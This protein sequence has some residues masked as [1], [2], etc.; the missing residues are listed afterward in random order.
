MGLRSSGDLTALRTARD[1]GRRDASREERAPRRSPARCRPRSRRSDV[2]RQVA[3]GQADRRRRDGGRL[4]GHASQRA[5]GGPQATA[6]PVR[7]RS[8]DPQALSTRGVRRQQD[9]SP[10]RRRDPRRRHR[11]GRRTVSGHGAARRRVAVG[12]ALARRAACFP[13]PTRWPSR[14]RCSRCCRRRTTT[15]SSIAISSPGTSS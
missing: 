5:A 2:E 14:G 8:R 15:A 3:R 13:S 12:V 9:R 11:P 7:A 1:S 4:R 6:R 10:R